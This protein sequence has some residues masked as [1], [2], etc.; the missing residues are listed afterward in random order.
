MTYSFKLNGNLCGSVSPSWGLRQGDPISP[1]FFLLCDEAFS[2]LLSQ[3]T[4]DGS[5]HG[6]RVC[7]GDSRVSHILFDDDNILFARETLQECSNMADIISLY[8]RA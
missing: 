7:K 1:Y 6:A 8:D 3:A 4:T 5:I 2:S